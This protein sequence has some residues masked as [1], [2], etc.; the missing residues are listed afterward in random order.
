MTNLPWVQTEAVLSVIAA[1]EEP[2]RS[3]CDNATIIEVTG[4][5]AGAVGRILVQLWAADEIEGL[6]TLG[7]PGGGVVS[8][9]GIRRVLPDRERL[10][11]KEGRYRS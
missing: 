3:E 8:L 9:V 10:W 4:L 6:R 2:D 7:G 5:D 1:A 11:G